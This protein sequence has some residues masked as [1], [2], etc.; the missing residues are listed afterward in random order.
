M[1]DSL[2]EQEPRLTKEG[3][4]IFASPRAV[5]NKAFHFGLRRSEKS[6]LAVASKR[7]RSADKSL[8]WTNEDHSTC[9]G[10]SLRDPK[11][12]YAYASN[13]DFSKLLTEIDDISSHSS[14]ENKLVA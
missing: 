1:R 10:E 3:F 8:T 13:G 6:P 5:S 11:F 12:N 14:T 7:K 2:K 9:F 4:S